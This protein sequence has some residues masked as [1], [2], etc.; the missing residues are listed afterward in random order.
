MR[1]T[2]LVLLLLFF[3]GQ[4]FASEEIDETLF[5]QAQ[6]VGIDSIVDALPEQAMDIY[7]GFQSPMQAD[8]E[9]GIRQILTN[10]LSSLGTGLR[11]AFQSAG[12]L[13]SVVLLCCL[14][15]L[16]AGRAGGAVRIA[17][18]LAATLICVAD[19]NTL[20]GLGRTTMEETAVFSAAILPM[21]S[22]A[23]SASGAPATA[24]ALYA[25][26]VFLTQILNRVLLHVF[27]P[28]THACLAVACAEFVLE[29]SLL[30]RIRLLMQGIVANGLKGLL[31]SFSAYLALT[32]VVSGSADSATVKAAKLALSSIV[33]V[34]GSV[35]ADASETVLVSAGI[36]KSAVGVI[37][38]LGVCAVCAAPFLRLGTHYLTLKVTA[39]L[40]S[41]LDDGTA[42]RM[43]DASASAMGMILAMVG[44]SALF[45][46]IAC[47][48]FLKAVVPG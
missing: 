17:S 39:A 37:G 32:Q 9:E 3:S 41:A 5:Q 44:A 20:V 27:L 1:G 16:V 38:V 12:K 7:D 4:A 24:A 42:S 30:K 21:L 11:A 15:R 23:T 13:L 46:L 26:T 33:P 18:V 34:V 25:A 43:I 28:I 19:L 31:V 14:V 40:S 10:S 22:S 48:C 45:N 36:L 8:L 29:D 35:I 47:V 6:I 2:I